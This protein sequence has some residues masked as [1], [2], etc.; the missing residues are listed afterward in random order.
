MKLINVE[1]IVSFSKCNFNLCRKTSNVIEPV[2]IN[3]KSKEI[4]SNLSIKIVKNFSEIEHFQLNIE[5]ISFHIIDIDYRI[6]HS[7]GISAPD[8]IVKK[9]DIIGKKI[10]DIYPKECSDFFLDLLDCA[11]KTKE[12]FHIVL[13]IN[14]KPHEVWIIPV[15]SRSNEI[16]GYVYFKTPYTSIESLI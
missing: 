13:S 8:L 1:N 10:Q 12:D 11:K 16:F 5:K 9:E 4:L 3:K 14:G 2:K 6:L 7:S 15:L